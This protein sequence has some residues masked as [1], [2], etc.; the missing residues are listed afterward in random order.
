MS[1]F[2]SNEDIIM[3]TFSN[4]TRQYL[5]IFY[6]SFIFYYYQQV[7]FTLRVS[8]LLS[9]LNDAS[10]DIADY[11]SSFQFSP[12]AEFKSPLYA[13]ITLTD[14]EAESPY[15]TPLLQC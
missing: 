13:H 9:S 10:G 8:S 5:N 3:K 2:L 4:S 12:E 11:E 6:V 14:N 7:L 15:F 1:K